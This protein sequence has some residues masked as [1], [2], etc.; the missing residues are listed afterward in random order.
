[1]SDVNVGVKYLADFEDF[2]LSHRLHKDIDETRRGHTAINIGYE[3]GEWN[4][5]EFVL[6]LQR[7][8]P[9]FSLT[10]KELTN[11]NDPTEFFAIV[12]NAAR[13]L[14]DRDKK[15]DKKGEIG[16]LILHGL[17]RDIYKTSPLVSK[18][19]Y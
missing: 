3:S 10:P 2:K 12:T 11:F 13:L 6:W 16:E 8:I 17:I 1:M 7:H 14:H 18:V 19:Y 4:Y 5:R 9:E 15:L